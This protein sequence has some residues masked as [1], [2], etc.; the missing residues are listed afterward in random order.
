MEMS[1]STQR[2]TSQIAEEKQEADKHTVY[3]M[4]SIQEQ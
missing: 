2:F 1:E 4:K 3:F